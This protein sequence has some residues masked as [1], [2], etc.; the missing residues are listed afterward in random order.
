MNMNKAFYPFLFAAILASGMYLG[1]KIQDRNAAR[2]KVFST[3]GS[4]KLD[5][6]LRL[7]DARYVDD[8]EK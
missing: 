4:S 7:I 5:Y 8:A 2:S 6:I 3:E 1:Y